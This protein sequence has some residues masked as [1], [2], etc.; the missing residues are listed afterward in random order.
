MQPIDNILVAVD[1]YTDTADGTLPIEVTKATRFI[2]SK[3]GARVRLLACGYEKFL[4]DQ[5]YGFGDEL[6]S[7]REAHCQQLQE[8][9]DLIEGSL[10]AQGYQVSAELVWGYPRYE[11]VV[12]KAIAY[13]V[14]LV[15]YHTRPHAKLSRAVLSHDSW[16]L[17]RHCPKP[18]LLVK[19]RVW[20]ARP[21]VLAAVDPT[22]HHHK[23]MKLDH[24]I[25]DLGLST[26][27]HL[28]GDLHVLHA[29]G[30][31]GRPFALP[32][33][34]LQSHQDAFDALLADFTVDPARCHLVED[35]PVFALQS[36]TAKLNADII[37]MGALSRSRLSDAL[38]GSTAEAV[39]DYLDADVLIVKP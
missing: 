9:L 37:A 24:K 25:L 36:W 18:L 13:G 26:A 38:I 33:K 21:V 27:G 10:R 16:Q 30:D 20:N 14:D 17:V 5:Y 4:N 6:R 2:H 15:V 34:L 7:L 22:H 8:R 39:L 35:S 1:V 11:Q 28:E 29:Y 31:V 32:E 23:P 19:D 12:E 3:Q